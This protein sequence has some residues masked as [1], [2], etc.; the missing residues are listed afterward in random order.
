MR[1]AAGRKGRTRLLLTRDLAN[2]VDRIA[3]MDRGDRVKAWEQ[4]SVRM[5]TGRIGKR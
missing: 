4:A 1:C 5:I 2:E 3:G